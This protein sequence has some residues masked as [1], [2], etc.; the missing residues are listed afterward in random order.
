M[1][2]ARAAMKAHRLIQNAGYGPNR[3]NPLPPSE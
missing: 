2:K 3:D 1:E